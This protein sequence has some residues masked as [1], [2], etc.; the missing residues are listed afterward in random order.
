M[1]TNFKPNM[2]R[3]NFIKSTATLAAVA[4]AGSSM[5]SVQ[6][7]SPEKEFYEFRNYQLIGG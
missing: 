5:A 3:R 6:M 4:A 2:E 1:Q 7:P